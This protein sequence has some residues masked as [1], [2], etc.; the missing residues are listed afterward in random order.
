MSAIVNNVAKLI[1]SRLLP[2]KGCNLAA[3]L[4]ARRHLGLSAW[5]STDAAYTGSTAPTV[6]SPVQAA[7]KEQLSEFGEYVGECLPKYVQEVRLANQDELEILIHP[8]GVLPVLSFLKDHHQAQFVSL[9]DIACVDM[10]SRVFRFELNYML[11]SMRYNTRVRV[12]TYTDELTPVD[13]CTSIFQAADWYEREC[14][15]MFGVF[16]SNH[17][18]LRRILTDYGFEGHP[19]RKDFPLTGYTECRY[20]DDKQRV[21]FE[22]VELAQEF[23]KFDFNASWESFPAHRASAESKPE[24]EPK[25]K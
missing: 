19:F 23:R 2:S 6:R 16:F 12:R 25:E 3:G 15:D 21:V 14:W 1:C 24:P 7:R 10:P 22:P 11:L 4:G 20:D 8:D 17:P 5:A 13:S 18:D 9:A